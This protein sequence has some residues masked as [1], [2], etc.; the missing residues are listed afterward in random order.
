MNLGIIGSGN[1]GGT[2][3]RRFAQLGHSVAF[4]SRRPDSAEMAELARQHNAQVVSP[5]EAAQSAEVVLLA[6]PWPNTAEVLRGLGDLTG[7]IVLD[8]TNPLKPDLSG[9]AL[10]NTTSG[11][12]QVAGWAPGARVVKI[13]NTV[14]FGVMANPAFGS[15]SATMLYCGDDAAAKGVA[16]EL[17]AQL[18][19]DPVDA[20]P[21]KQARLLEPFALLWISLAIGGQ[22]INIA[23][24]LMHR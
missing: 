24:R 18:G 21:L 22:G 5:R 7:K 2:L 12:E 11:A 1:V 23:F 15:E 3:G 19:F 9:L 17:A 10:A 6:T 13:L 16:R 20:G 14:G 4:G 8:C